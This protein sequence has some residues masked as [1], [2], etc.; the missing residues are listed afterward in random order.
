MRKSNLGIISLI[1]S[2]IMG[3]SA[4]SGCGLIQVDNEKDLEQVI[5]TVR[6]TE[7]VPES[8]TS[9]ILKKDIVMAYMNY[10]YQ[11]E[12]SYGYNR[13][14]VINLIVRTLIEGRVLVQKAILDFESNIAPFDGVLQSDKDTAW[15]LDRYLDKD[16]RVDAEYSA[17]YDMNELIHSYMETHDHEK[18]QDSMIDTVSSIVK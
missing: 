7:E 5:A 1:M 12:Y 10:G 3:V 14:Q 8:E 15:D 2:L 17:I 13:E 11:Y 18:V 16:E 9:N 4:F 6:I